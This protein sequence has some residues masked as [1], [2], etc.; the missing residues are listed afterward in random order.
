M[1]QKNAVYKQT[2]WAS[3]RQRTVA[4]THHGLRNSVWMNRAFAAFAFLT[5]VLGRDVAKVQFPPPDSQLRLEATTFNGTARSTG[6]TFIAHT[7]RVP[8]PRYITVGILPDGCEMLQLTSYTSYE[9]DCMYAVN[10]GLFSMDPNVTDKC[11]GEVV[12]NGKRMHTSDVDWAVLGL[13]WSNETV[14]GFLGHDGE[15]KFDWRELVSGKV[16]SF[17]LFHA[18]LS[19]TYEQKLHSLVQPSCVVCRGG[20]FARERNL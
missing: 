11:I 14:V 12:R 10:G 6:R 5:V 9:L 1:H 16:C 3:A 17:L 13:T 15:S 8:D 20:W 2:D 19:D 7:A 4:T 18:M